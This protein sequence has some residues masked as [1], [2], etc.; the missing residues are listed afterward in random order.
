MPRL[1]G[2]GYK[3]GEPTRAVCATVPASIDNAIKS[4]IG[5]YGSYSGA[6]VSV[7]R[8]GLERGATGAP[9][10]AFVAEGRVEGSSDGESD[11][12]AV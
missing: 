12:R 6:L 10:T 8:T 5:D 1:K 7:L 11:S 9:R 2:T 3:H 4:I